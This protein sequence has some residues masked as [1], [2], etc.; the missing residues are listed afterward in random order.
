MI[1]RLLLLVH[2]GCLA[3]LMTQLTRRADAQ[4]PRSAPVGVTK[5]SD[6]WALDRIFAGQHLNESA[7]TVHRR[8]RA[9]QP[10]ARLIYLSRWVLPGRD[11]SAFRLAIGFEP[12]DQSPDGPPNHEI[13]LGSNRSSSPLRLSA[14]VGGRI[15]SPAFDLVA[16]ASQLGR[17]Q[18]LHESISAAETLDVTQEIERLAMLALVAIEANDTAR[19]ATLL[20]QMFVQALT[21]PATLHRSRDAALLCLHIAT[22]SP[23]LAQIVF[24][25]AQRISQQYLTVY[26][27]QAWE[28]HLLTTV[29]MLK[30]IV[31]GE[32]PDQK[33]T[34]LEGT[35]QWAAVAR[36]RAFEHGTGF[37]APQWRLEPTSARNLSSHGDDFLFFKVPLQGNYS[38]EADVTEFNWQ[39]SHLMVAGTWVAPI[40]G[41]RVYGFGSVRGEQARVAITPP[42]SNLNRSAPIHY[43]TSVSAAR[44]ITFFNGREIHTQ[45][46]SPVQD[47]WIA[48]RSSY[49]HNGGA[50]DLRISGTPTVPE[51]ISLS[52]SPD[53]PGW[54]EYYRKPSRDELV[55]WRH[56][57]PA[58]RS[59]SPTDATLA[60]I[61]GPRREE[62]PRGSHA[63]S[64]LVYTRPMLEDGTIEYEFWYEPDQSIVHP[65]LG[66]TCFLL[67]PDGVAIHHVTDGQYDQSSRRPDAILDEPQNRRG[68]STLPLL[69][70]S[71]N[72]MTLSLVGDQVALQLNGQRV[73]ER[74]VNSG[75]PRTFGLFHYADREQARVRQ[76]RWSGNWPKQLP[77]LSDQQLAVI[78][79]ALSEDRS[80]ALAAEFSESFNED[81]FSSRRFK[82]TEGDPAKHFLATA[83]GLAV[84]RPAEVG[85]R[86]AMLSPHI[87]IGGDFDVTVRFEQ[88]DTHALPD[89]TATVML[90]VAASNEASDV[91]SLQ[92]K[93]D[94]Q[95]DQ[96]MQC[97]HMQT[98]A[99]TE[100]RH[101]F[102]H[103]CVEATAGR[104]RLSRR[105]GQLF[106]QFAENDSDQF[107]VIGR[108]DFSTADLTG[109]AIRF[110]AQIQG[111]TGHT[112]VRFLDFHARAERMEGMALDSMES[113]L[114]DLKQSS[115]K[116]SA[117]LHHDFVHAAPPASD[118]VRWNADRDW[119][120]AD[121]G[122]MIQAL[123]T[124]EWTSSGIA[125]LRQIEGDFD[126]RIEF[127]PKQLAIPA[128]GQ[129]TAIYLQ[130]E[131][132][133]A[134]RTQI[135][136]T[137]V[138]MPSGTVVANAKL[139]A[140]LSPGEF[141]YRSLGAI[142]MAS[143][144]QLRLVRR[145]GRVFW[146]AGSETAGDETIVSFADVGDAAVGYGSIRALV[147][148]GGEGRSSQVLLRSLDVNAEVII[149]RPQIDD[150]QPQPVPGAPP[151]ANL[152]PANG[153]L[154]SQRPKSL[155][156]SL[157]DIF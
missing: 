70:G 2:F 31:E 32:Q 137:L 71:W 89:M 88:L 43:R 99:E 34:A 96:V 23:K 102:N 106:Y 24:D 109:Q 154:P 60:E 92:R 44:A 5:R 40:H 148:T 20:E 94:R 107:R 27:R 114:A 58:A 131:L 87:E 10:E 86:N 83:E 117:V 65:V 78:E 21:D 133:D 17:L 116:L 126:I 115:E 25:P 103:H 105:G 120:Q 52:E 113:K 30:E 66:R 49:R 80:Q 56:Q 74:E 72:R 104:M 38:V 61:V 16:T 149:G 122:L 143:A 62:L 141:Q 152:P 150:V 37:P 130:V 142:E 3:P 139:R 67:K 57:A 111:T 28:Q 123:G 112:H 110:G 82:V 138:R 85:Y 19:A 155:F 129:E 135:N 12:L 7:L 127:D 36:S 11:H 90:N 77:V 108:A 15:V 59:G 33:A 75:A 134:D 91:G 121:R 151:A 13:A 136:S 100:R 29:A 93:R 6:G 35:Q 18:S 73:Y 147:H 63:E 156:Q 118:F 97:L 1:F 101:Y 144:K 41:H 39:D 55:D 125:L 76:I 79:P 119:S 14:P 140:S 81:I 146:I 153:K 69:S 46:L 132:A 54:F 48:I 124:E 53:L 47:P 45:P 128:A 157:F 50:D 145:G 26:D 68:S 84:R 9:M 22:G 42:L 51:T 4:E 8:A 64:L 98:I 95:G